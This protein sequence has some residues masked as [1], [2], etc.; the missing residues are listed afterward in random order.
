MAKPVKKYLETLEWEV[1]IHAPYSPDF[2]PSD[3]NLFL[4]MAHR[5]SRKKLKPYEDSKNY[6]ESWIAFKDED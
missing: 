5:L 4:S 2:A 3:Y 6:I 1:L